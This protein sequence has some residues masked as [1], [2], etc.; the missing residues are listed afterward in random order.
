M[1]T[2]LDPFE[3]EAMAHAFADAAGVHWG[4]CTSADHTRFMGEGRAFLAAQAG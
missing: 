2:D 4:T 3:V 1:T